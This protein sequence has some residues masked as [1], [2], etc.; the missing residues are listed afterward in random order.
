MKNRKKRER[1]IHSWPKHWPV[2][3]NQNSALYSKSPINKLR[4][5]TFYRKGKTAPPQN[6]HT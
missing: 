3:E 4:Q 1:K 5:K 6:F 2:P